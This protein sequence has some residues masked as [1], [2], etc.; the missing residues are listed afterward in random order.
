MK[1]DKDLQ[2][3]IPESH[4][5]VVEAV[6]RGFPKSAVIGALLM[7]ALAGSLWTY[8]VP[9]SIAGGILATLV[10]GHFIYKYRSDK[11]FDKRMEALKARGMEWKGDADS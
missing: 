9:Q 8:I 6:P 11:A 1:K 7:G 4:R 3:L 2:E 5:D 10:V